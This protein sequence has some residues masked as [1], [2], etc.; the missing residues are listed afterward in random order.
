MDTIGII[1]G[2]GRLPLLEARG[3]RAAGFRVA[4]VG[5]GD[6]L[7]PELP[8]A[9]DEFRRVAIL[10]L[11][12]W[13]WLL[14]GWGCRQAIM[15]GVVKKTIV[16]HPMGMLREMPD[17]RVVNLWFRKLR[18]DKR[19]QILLTALADELEH[20]GV[21][22]IDTTRYI[23]E[24]LATQGVMTRRQPSAGVRA[25][26][27]FGWPILMRMNDLDIGQAIAVRGR[28]VVAVEAVE[29]TDRMI[30]RAGELC[31]GRGWTLCKGPR[32]DKDMRFDVPTVGVDTI[33]RLRECGAA[34]LAVA[35]GKVILLDRPEL[36]KAADEAGIAVVGVGNQEVAS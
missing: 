19:S 27:E 31:R 36:L 26:I 11:G 14:R 30:V 35:A 16:Y 21:E 9:C 5:L 6:G 23:A 8:A 10:R 13:G 3:L 29:G 34:A 28:D 1:A 18:H 7:D 12:R 24:H 15:V 33:H 4:C 22:L 2:R 17:W 20:M 25:D 32:P